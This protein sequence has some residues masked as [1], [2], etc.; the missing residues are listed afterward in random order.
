MLEINEEDRKFII[1][2]LTDGDKLIENDD[3]NGIINAL[4]M[5]ELMKGYDG[6]WEDGI[7]HFGRQIERV[8]DRLFYENQ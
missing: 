7:N 6:A 2:N 3:L 8:I 1:R 5:L 4:N